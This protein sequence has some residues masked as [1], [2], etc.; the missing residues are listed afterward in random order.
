MTE[1]RLNII[2][3]VGQPLSGKDSVARILAERGYAHVSTGDLLRAYMQEVGLGEPTRPLTR[4]TANALRAEHGPD[5]L[6]H[7]ALEK[8]PDHVVVGGIRTVP[9]AEA[10]KA[11]G[12]R[13]VWVEAPQPLRFERLSV[14]NRT[15]D[16]VTIEEFQAQE[17]A[18]TVSANPNEQNVGA[19][20]A[21]ADVTVVNDGD[22]AALTTAVERD[23]LGG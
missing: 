10:L 21:L 20:E 3:V 11:A 8:H 23:V 4:S 19:L 12:G 13:I 22:L 17:A 5:Y 7:L 18:E 16:D 15:G 1:S 9:E 2:G 6:V 14:R